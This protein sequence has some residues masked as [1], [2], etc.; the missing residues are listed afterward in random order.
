MR[1][2]LGGGHSTFPAVSPGVS[3]GDGASGISG[4][5]GSPVSIPSGVSS[6]SE[7]TVCQLSPL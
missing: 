3:G 1:L 6:E 4:V 7:Y 2:A 5:G